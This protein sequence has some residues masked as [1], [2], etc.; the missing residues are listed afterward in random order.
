MARPI[1][2][3]C[4]SFEAFRKPPGPSL[5]STAPLHAY[6]NMYIY[7]T[8]VCIMREQELGALNFGLPFFRVGLKGGATWE[9]MFERSE[10]YLPPGTI[11]Q[12][13][14]SRR[15]TPNLLKGGD[16]PLLC[17][18][19]IKNPPVPFEVKQVFHPSASMWTG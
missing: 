1:K 5:L 8:C 10:S 7:K 13:A 17:R 9:P 11:A 2:L 15:H 6:Y 16:V 14:R 18:S 19:D 4:D 3:P 12:S